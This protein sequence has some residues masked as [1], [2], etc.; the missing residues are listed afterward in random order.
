MDPTPATAGP[1]RERANSRGT[2]VPQSASQEL[3]EVVAPYSRQAY[4]HNRFGRGGS[5]TSFYCGGN[6][7]RRQSGSPFSP[8]N[9]RTH[10]FSLILYKDQVYVPSL[11]GKE[12]WQLAG[13]GEKTSI[14]N[15]TGDHKHIEE[16]LFAAF[17][18]LQEAGGFLLLRSGSR[19]NSGDGTKL[20]QGVRG[21][22]DAV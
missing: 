19:S 2:N 18:K 9:T 13:M 7:G 20:L 15:K 21:I 12:M 14:F 17:P 5:A 10:K 8:A 22:Y 11:A 1:S 4:Q 6:A 16:K 3:R